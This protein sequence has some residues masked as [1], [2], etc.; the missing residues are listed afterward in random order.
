VS[1][2]PRITGDQCVRA[3]GQLGLQL[4]RTKGSHVMMKGAGGR[5][6]VVPCH[7]GETLGPGILSKILTTAGVSRQ[8]FEAQL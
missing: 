7:K 6:A 2:L 5:Y 1:R 3:L 8:D 4:I